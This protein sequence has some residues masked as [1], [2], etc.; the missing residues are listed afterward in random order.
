MRSTELHKNVTPFPL[1]RRFFL[2]R[3]GKKNVGDTGFEI[4]EK[5]NP[6]R[7]CVGFQELSFFVGFLYKT[8]Q[9]RQASRLAD[10]QI[11]TV[12][13]A[14]FSDT[15]AA[16]FEKLIELFPSNEPSII[17]LYVERLAQRLFVFFE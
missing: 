5:G 8:P 4:R 14:S 1:G 3:S 6:A 17:I 15:I 12:V 7:K 11:L 9:I 10:E 16:G 13:L 2:P